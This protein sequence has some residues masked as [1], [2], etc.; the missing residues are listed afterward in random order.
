TDTR[1]RL[2]GLVRKKPWQRGFFYWVVFPELV[3]V[4]VKQPFGG[5]S[6]TVRRGRPDAARH[7][8]APRGRRYQWPRR[9]TEGAR[10]RQMVAVHRSSGPRPGLSSCV[11]ASERAA[12]RDDAWVKFDCTQPVSVTA[13]PD[14]PEWMKARPRRRA[15]LDLCA[16]ELR[17]A[18]LRERVERLRVRARFARCDGVADDV[19]LLGP[20]TRARHPAA[21]HGTVVLPRSIHRD[22]GDRDRRRVR[23]R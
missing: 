5:L 1:T 4:S 18:R 3:L 14:S 22:H 23:H 13:S 21:A 12:V 10:R 15:T 11:R 17:R 2:T 16:S 20:R 19:D 9:H 6:G 8:P 7:R